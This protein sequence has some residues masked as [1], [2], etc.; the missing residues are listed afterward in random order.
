VNKKSI[1][2]VLVLILIFVTGC[3]A[4]K[5]TSVYEYRTS[6][7]DIVPS[8]Y[9]VKTE[10]YS[11]KVV[12]FWDGTVSSLEDWRFSDDFIVKGKKLILKTEEPSAF[13]S[14]SVSLEDF[15]YSFRY[16]DSEQYACLYT[17]MDSEGGL[18]FGGSIDRYYT[19][20]EI[21]RQKEQVRKREEEE[22]EIFGKLEGLWVC[23]DGDYIRVYEDESYTLE[24][25]VNDEQGKESS[26]YFKGNIYAKEN[27]MGVFYNDGLFE[28][29]FT[30]V[31]SEDGSS[32]EYLDK[33]F[34][35]E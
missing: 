35:H 30:V 10:Y 6:G 33:I 34:V 1:L 23:E 31:L 13:N 26:I 8:L 16:L 20:E 24:Y 32:F 29:G 19:D 7:D 27:N 25:S 21:E 4:S 14:F 2:C 12:I 15:S 9:L 3:S 5:A 17:V 22:K 18:D 11:D 28:V